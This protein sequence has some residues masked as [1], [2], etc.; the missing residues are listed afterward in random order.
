MAFEDE[1]TPLGALVT[2]LEEYPNA[3]M[4]NYLYVGGDDMAS[5]HQ[6]MLDSLERFAKD[7]DCAGMEII[8]R[9]GWERFMK[10]FGWET[11]H[12][13]CEKFFTDKEKEDVAA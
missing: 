12:I 10:K 1:D 7:N 13:V 2:R 3:R 11:K 8:G 6:E 5:W 4:L 9:K